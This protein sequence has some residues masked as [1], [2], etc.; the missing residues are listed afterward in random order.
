M[1][2]SC[3]QHT[4]RHK[5]GT[6]EQVQGLRA[7]GTDCEI[8]VS[9]SSLVVEKTSETWWQFDGYKVIF[10]ATFLYEV[11]CRWQ[12]L[13]HVSNPEFN[14]VYFILKLHGDTSTGVYQNMEKTSES[15]FL[16]TAFSRAKCRLSG[17]NF[18]FLSNKI[19][20][21]NCTPLVYFDERNA[22]QSISTVIFEF[23]VLFDTLSW[24]AS[25]DW[26]VFQYSKIGHAR[27]LGYFTREITLKNEFPSQLL[28]DRKVLWMTLEQLFEIFIKL[29]I[30]DNS[31]AICILL[32]G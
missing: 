30:F 19:S 10:E 3:R 4:C 11:V 32:R 24:F 27:R 12:N 25:V 16:E 13:C 5:E 28:P 8:L 26:R 9:L 31:R 18:F 29:P 15:S 7:Q 17:N 23:F 20:N 2:T 14:D 6:R 21:K 1:A 22:L